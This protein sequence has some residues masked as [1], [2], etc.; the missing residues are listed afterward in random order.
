MGNLGYQTEQW[1]LEEFFKDCGTI[2]S[3]RIAMGEDGRPRGFAHV[4]F[5]D[6]AAAQ[7]GMKL[8]G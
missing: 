8:A 6:A 3:V 1:A 2:S 4:E 5:A 7:E